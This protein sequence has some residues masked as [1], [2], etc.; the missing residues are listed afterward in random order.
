MGHALLLGG[1]L[2]EVWLSRSEGGGYDVHLGGK[3]IGDHGRA[4]A[5]AVSGDDV[6][7]HLDGE[8]HV[9][10]FA[11]ALERHAA[12]AS[13]EGGAVARAPMPGNVIAVSVA[14]G[15]AVRRGQ[16]LLVIESMKMETTITAPCDGRVQDVHVTVGR[17][18]ERDAVLVTLE[19]EAA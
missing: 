17:T 6:H 12:A 19:V 11:D 3:V 4:V 7:L 1:Q 14:A 5:V 9:I 8:T 15:D 10:C 2:H 16:P 18:F 13:E